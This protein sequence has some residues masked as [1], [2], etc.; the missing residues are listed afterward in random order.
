MTRKL[1]LAVAA[2][3]VCIAC[4]RTSPPTPFASVVDE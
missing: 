3:A 2:L 4:Q 1:A